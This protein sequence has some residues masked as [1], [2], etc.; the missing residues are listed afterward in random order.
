MQYLSH[1]A[2]CL[3]S[4]LVIV[5]KIRN[6]T[7]H[8]VHHFKCFFPPAL[9]SVNQNKLSHNPAQT[10]DF[11][12]HNV[13][14]EILQNLRTV[15]SNSVEHQVQKNSNIKQR[16]HTAQSRQQSAV[17]IYIVHLSNQ[18]QVGFILCSSA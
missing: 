5:S 8:K 15:L 6:R 17:T 10:S 9:N 11:W 2:G 13:H 16:A 4:D 7:I 12:R 3:P 1:K 18:S 14:A